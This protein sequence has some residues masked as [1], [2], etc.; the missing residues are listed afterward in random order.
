MWKKEAGVT[1]KLIQSLPTKELGDFHYVSVPRVGEWLLTPDNDGSGEM[2][3]VVDAV[4][5]FPTYP[6]EPPGVAVHVT[7]HKVQDLRKRLERTISGQRSQ[8]TQIQIVEKIQKR[9]QSR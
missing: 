8:A 6:K 4:V 1:I 2:A 7:A 3:W 5:Y 9:R